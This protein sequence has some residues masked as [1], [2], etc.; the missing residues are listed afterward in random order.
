KVKVYS[1]EGKHQKV[2]VP[3]PADIDAEK[4]RAL[5]VFRTAEGDLVP[6]VHNWETLSLYPDHIGWRG[7][8]MPELTCPA[9][10]SRGRGYWLVQGP[11]L[12]AVDA[13]GGI[14]YD[15][16]LGPR[17]LPEIKDLR[18]GGELSSFWSERPCL[19]VSSDDKYVYFAGLS[20]GAGDWRKAQPLP[21]VFR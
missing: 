4:V 1:R 5:G 21:C 3:F 15:A 13:D 19:A 18:L 12:V 9:V 2:I 10:D 14:P 17:L 11:S 8:D 7:R 20:K 6:H 16:F